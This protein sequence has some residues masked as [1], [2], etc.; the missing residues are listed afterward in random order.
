MGLGSSASMHR[1]R[2]ARYTRGISKQMSG[3]KK[4]LKKKNCATANTKLVN[5][6]FF[7]GGALSETKG[8][9]KGKKVG[10][11]RKRAMK[12]AATKRMNSAL[13]AYRKV[14]HAAPKK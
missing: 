2:R 5:I 10:Y 13:K 3:F 9:D 12:M 4:A 11:T 14:C 7:A 8:S 1:K 6:A